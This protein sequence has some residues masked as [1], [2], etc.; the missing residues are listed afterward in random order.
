MLLIPGRKSWSC[1]VKVYTVQRLFCPMHFGTGH[2]FLVHGDYM[3]ALEPVP[4][5]T[6]AYTPQAP[7]RSS[8]AATTY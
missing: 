1:P 5:M 3:E 8:A 4:Q 2:S 7:I 6:G